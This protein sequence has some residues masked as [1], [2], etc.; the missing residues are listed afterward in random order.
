[1][2]NKK[3]FNAMGY[4][5]G[6]PADAGLPGCEFI[7]TCNRNFYG[8]DS[9][10]KE[11][12]NIEPK[13]ATDVEA[14]LAALD[15]TKHVYFDLE[16]WLA[17]P[18]NVAPLDLIKI[19]NFKLWAGTLLKKYKSK[20]PTGKVFVYG[21]PNGNFNPLNPVAA[22]ESWRTNVAVPTLSGGELSKLIMDNIDAL[23]FSAYPSEYTG[24]DD[25]I[26]SFPTQIKYNETML[27]VMRANNPRNLPIYAWVQPRMAYR[28]DGKRYFLDY[29]TMLA[30]VSWCLTNC[31]GIVLWDWDGYGDPAKGTPVAPWDTS[32]PWYQA[33]KDCL[34]ANEAAP[35]YSKLFTDTINKFPASFA[36]V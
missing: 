22:T 29:K 4:R 7:Q 30:N 33:V 5:T 11:V 1:M 9:T 17:D 35:T 15:T 28:A 21:H 20:N 31:D 23:T 8:K 26:G 2:P 27:G 12:P 19:Y 34:A 3:V 16:P 24:K 25:P 10:G 13:W 36:S 18:Y 6:M 32:M 14:A